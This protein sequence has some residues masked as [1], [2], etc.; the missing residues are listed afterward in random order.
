MTALACHSRGCMLAGCVCHVHTHPRLASWTV[1]MSLYRT[2]RNGGS[3]AAMP[4][5]NAT[6]NSVRPPHSTAYPTARKL[7]RY[8]EPMAHGPGACEPSHPC[9]SR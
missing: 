4:H 8:P 5:G 6:A 2:T 7:K 3:R 9:G 1:T